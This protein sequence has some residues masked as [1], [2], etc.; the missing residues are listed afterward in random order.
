MSKADFYKVFPNVVASD[1]YSGG[2]G[3]YHYTK[4]PA[5]SDQFLVHPAQPLESTP[6][7]LEQKLR[8]LEDRIKSPFVS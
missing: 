3:E 5:K 6:T 4:P 1:S 2:R 7:D 8:Q